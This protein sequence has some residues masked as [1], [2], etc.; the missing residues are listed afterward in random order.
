VSAAAPTVRAAA[1]AS[2]ADGPQSD[3]VLAAALLA[4]VQRWGPGVRLS[5]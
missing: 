3:E 5:N 2:G 1:Q 4:V